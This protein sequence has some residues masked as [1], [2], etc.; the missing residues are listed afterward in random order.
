[1]GNMSRRE[2]NQRYALK[3]RLLRLTGLIQNEFSAG[4]LLFSMEFAGLIGPVKLETVKACIAGWIRRAKRIRNVQGLDVRYIRAT[5]MGPTG[6]LFRVLMNYAGDE[7]AETLLFTW[8]YG[9]IT[10]V[11]LPSPFCPQDAARLLLGGKP[12]TQSSSPSTCL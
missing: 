6:P 8:V 4:D 5:G 7:D 3:V 2:S 11:R 1:M 12:G 9:K 10:M